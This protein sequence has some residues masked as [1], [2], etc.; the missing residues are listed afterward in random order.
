MLALKQ[1]QLAIYRREGL[2]I[3]EGE[4]RTGKVYEKLE[5]EIEKERQERAEHIRNL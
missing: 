4:D 3:N 1:K 5:Q 2:T